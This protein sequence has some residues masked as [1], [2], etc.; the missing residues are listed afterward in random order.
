MCQP[1]GSPS[2]TVAALPAAQPEMAYSDP[3]RGSGSLALPA[4]LSVAKL[5]PSSSGSSGSLLFQL[6]QLPLQLCLRC[7]QA[8]RL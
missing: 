5:L 1:Q 3:R 2:K 4:R 7:A 8:Q 6:L